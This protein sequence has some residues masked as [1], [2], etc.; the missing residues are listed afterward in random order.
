MAHRGPAA[1]PRK[2]GH[3]PT[4]DWADVPNVPY[5]GPSPDLP[6]LTRRR[7]W[8]DE[9]ADWWEEVR[10]MPHCAMWTATDW[11]FA[12]ETAFMK[13]QFWLELDEGEMKTTT[14]TEIRRRED[15]MGTTGEARRKLR[16]RYIEVLDEQER[17]PAPM[18][19]PTSAGSVE[20]G[21]VTSL[22]ERR[23]RLA[24]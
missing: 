22:T 13:Q 14:A 16:V 8:R 10:R 17:V 6:K 12:I 7:R 11:R 18:V 2:L 20:N 4:S 9:V 15:Q 21:V 3:S 24:G 5:E 1:S 23:R 19:A